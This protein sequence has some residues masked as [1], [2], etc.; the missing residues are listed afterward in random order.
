MSKTLSKNVSNDR[1][2]IKNKCI[3][4]EENV[5]PVDF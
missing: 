3:S 2:M 5:K 4:L 1:I